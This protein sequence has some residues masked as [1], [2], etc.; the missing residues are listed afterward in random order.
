M[1]L[2]TYT[3]IK[4]LRKKHRNGN[5]LTDNELQKLRQYIQIKQQAP[6]NTGEQLEKLRK[7]ESLYYRITGE[8]L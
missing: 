3:K 6:T 8:E 5:D 1:N 4:E 2:W 7:A